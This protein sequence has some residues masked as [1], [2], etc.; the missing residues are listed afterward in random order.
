[1]DGDNADPRP[2][3]PALSVTPT[4]V[5]HS[6]GRLA[7]RR[8]QPAAL[9]FDEVFLSRRSRRALGRATLRDELG[10]LSYATASRF[11]GDHQGLPRSLRPALAAGGLH[12]V[13]AVLVS[14]SGSPRAWQCRPEAEAV[15]VLTIADPGAIRRLRN[16]A[17]DLLPDCSRCDLVV[18]VAD[19]DLL[20]AAYDDWGSLAW[21][22]AGALLQTLALA[23]TA[24]GLGFCPLGLLGGAVL[25]ALAAPSRFRALGA[26]V[27]GV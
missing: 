15:D 24:L 13:N 11:E 9:M 6:R 8:L 7:V 5:G 19:D 4:E 21:R 18:L 23:A 26:A 25:E 20:A 3:R 12:A 16:E 14:G 22:D 17:R 1:M 2:K 10:W 27:I